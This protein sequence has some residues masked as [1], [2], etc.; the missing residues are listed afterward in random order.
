MLFFVAGVVFAF[1]LA[2]VIVV[3][4]GIVVVVILLWLSGVVVCSCWTTYKTQHKT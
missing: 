4:V 3:G 2:G 1:I